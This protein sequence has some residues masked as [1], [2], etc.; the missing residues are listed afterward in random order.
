LNPQDNR[1]PWRFG[2]FF[3]LLL[4]TA[5][6]VTSFVV[7]DRAGEMAEEEAVARLRDA[8]HFQASEFAAHLIEPLFTA[9]ALA[10]TLS[11]AAESVAATVDKEIKRTD[12]DPLF[13]ATLRQQPDYFGVW[14]I[15]GPDC[16]GKEAPE[17]AG[18]GYVPYAYRKNGELVFEHDDF[19]VD[20]ELDYYLIP[21]QRKRESIIEPYIDPEA[22][23]VLMSSLAVP[24]FAK[25]EVI[26]VTG[27]DV[28]LASLSERISRVRPYDEGHAILLSSEGFIVAHSDPKLAGKKMSLAGIDEAHLQKIAQG[29]EFDEIRPDPVT[30]KSAWYTF[31]PV[32]IGHTGTS[33][34]MVQV[35]PVD[36]IMQRAESITRWTSLIAVLSIA[37][38]FAVLILFIRSVVGPLHESNQ[39]VR[40]L[41]DSMADGVA[42]H[43]GKGVIRS[44]NKRFPVLFGLSPVSIEGVLMPD[45]LRLHGLTSLYENLPDENKDASTIEQG[46]LTN[47]RGRT[48]PVEISA[49]RIRV[50]GEVCFLTVIRDISVRVLREKELRDT[51][52]RIRRQEKAVLQLA[53]HTP[54]E[55]DLEAVF[56]ITSELAAETLNTARVGIWIGNENLGMITCVDLFDTASGAHSSGIKICAG[57]YPEYFKAISEGRC[58]YAHDA[59]SDPRTCAFN[60][61]LLQP[62]GITS[63]LDS[64]IRISGSIE[65]IICFEHIGPA[66]V[67]TDDEASFASQVADQVAKAIVHARM[68]QEEEHRRKLETQFQHTQ[69]LESL[70]IM[71][72]GIAHDFNN[73]LLTIIGNLEMSLAEI[74]CNTPARQSLEESRKASLLAADL[75]GQMLAYSGKGHFI[76]NAISLAGIAKEMIALLESSITK[77]ADLRLSCPDELPL[78]MGDSAQLR[79]IIL[80]LILNAA[81]AM[82]GPDGFID[83]RL[84]TLE[85][86]DSFF[87]ETMVK[88]PLAPGTYV[89]LEVRDNG[90]G[91]DEQTR[92]RIFDP[93]FTT[94]FTGRGLGLA[95]VLGIVRGHRG[96]ILID[97]ELG[98]GTS[99]RILLPV[100]T[101]ATIE[102]ST[103]TGRAPG[104]APISPPLQENATVLLVDDDD[105]VRTTISRQL[106]R[107]GF[108]VIPA[109]DGFEAVELVERS[110][111]SGGRESHE[112]ID[113]VL[114]DL[115]MPRMDGAET[116]EKLHSIAP[117]LPIVLC[118]G[119]SDDELRARFEGKAIA[120]YLCK[121]FELRTLKA[122]VTEALDPL[123][124]DKPSDR[125]LCALAG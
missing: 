9:R 67:W 11:A 88:D 39:T 113:I 102:Q 66:R 98:K 63:M 111:S 75:C 82:T 56:R 28:E 85:C 18:R 7:A 17:S 109:A 41:L 107:L 73:L 72:G 50:S 51:M 14:A 37:V 90:C 42:M 95:A 86:D 108:R 54:G 121:P 119:Y 81:D 116:F 30:G 57:D 84:G 64:V 71:A 34:T 43:D 24:V 19:S 106:M 89:E 1:I 114:L 124:G 8:G 96:A 10:T 87:E 99:F 5:F 77:R 59:Q 65:G 60:E 62:H 68:K 2:A 103:T 53:L 3:G 61:I 78:V 25:G 118:S 12:F 27:V 49:R 47:E 13:L 45:L 123:S 74:P 35:V 117:D 100:A 80:N 23:H 79:Q 55:N 105:G 38:L 76:I 110:F 101:A 32:A 52:L 16:F 26:G 70:G 44:F 69:K 83:I 40:V 112:S 22:G 21:T 125:E 36:L 104:T 97:S 15:F 4:V 94:K 6:I 20:R 48:Y 93:F 122:A 33:W 120:G 46:T 92:L 91:M 31:T 115:T 29:A 58:I